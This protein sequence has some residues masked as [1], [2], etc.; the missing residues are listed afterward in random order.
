MSIVSGDFNTPTT[1]SSSIDSEDFST[2]FVIMENINNDDV[3]IPDVQEPVSDPTAPMTLED[4]A[5]LMV[6]G[7]ADVN[8]RIDRLSKSTEDDKEITDRRIDNLILANNQLNDDIKVIQVRQLM[9]DGY[10][11]L[12]DN[13]VEE[14]KNINYQSNQDEALIEHDDITITG[15]DL[16]KQTL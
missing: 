10:V 7:F 6:N 4:L 12:T 1:R 15:K 9:T 16:S 3:N 2:P 13:K 5:Q 8:A 14:I 11:H